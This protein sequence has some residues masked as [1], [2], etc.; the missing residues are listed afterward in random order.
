MTAADLDRMSLRQRYPVRAKAIPTHADPAA[1][2]RR[3]AVLRGGKGGPKGGKVVRGEK[4][5]L[6]KKGIKAKRAARSAVRGFNVFQ[7]NREM[8]DFV[9]QDGDI[10]VGS[11][12]WQVCCV[13]MRHLQF[14]VLRR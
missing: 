8:H 10:K 7:V 2:Q 11:R 14:H 4:E 1:Q 3:Q 9:Q 13:K 12:A 5:R 6:R